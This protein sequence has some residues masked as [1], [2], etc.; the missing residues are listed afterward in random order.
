MAIPVREDQ[1]DEVV[2]ALRGFQDAQRATEY[3]SLDAEDKEVLRAHR[4]QKARTLLGNLN[5]EITKPI[6]A[7]VDRPAVEAEVT[8]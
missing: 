8:A 6:A 7:F 5:I 4:I 3:A 1:I 2:A